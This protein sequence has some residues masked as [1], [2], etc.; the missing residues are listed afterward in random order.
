MTKLLYFNFTILQYSGL[1]QPVNWPTGWKTRL[2]PFYMFFLAFTFSYDT[3]SNIINLFMT[4]KTV[5][6]YAN[7]SFIL[8]SS[9]GVS[10]KMASNIGNRKRIAELVKILTS[11]SFHTRNPNEDKVRQQF[12]S[13]MK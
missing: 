5:S 3:I 10:V 1:W 2:Y 7:H 9:L 4:A 8:L 6:D 13:A 12:E 11:G